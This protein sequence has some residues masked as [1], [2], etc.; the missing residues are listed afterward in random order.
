MPS[1]SL[2]FPAEGREDA[3][4]GKNSSVPNGMEGLSK[5]TGRMHLEGI[6]AP[7]KTVEEKSLCQPLVLP[8]IHIHISEII[9]GTLKLSDAAP[10][11]GA[12]ADGWPQRPPLSRNTTISNSLFFFIGK[13]QGLKSHFV[14][15]KD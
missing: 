5:I 8:L 12:L 4:H 1:Q 2:R 7:N 10:S 9:R 13:T 14:Q 11:P 15:S 6:M 3:L